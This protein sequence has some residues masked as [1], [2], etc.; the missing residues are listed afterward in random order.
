[1]Q[2]RSAFYS[3]GGM[4]APIVAG[5]GLSMPLIICGLFC[6]STALGG[7]YDTIY[8]AL[9]ITPCKIDEVVDNDTVTEITPLTR[10]GGR[11]RGRSLSHSTAGEIVAS[12][13]SYG[14]RGGLV[15]VTHAL[16]AR[17]GEAKLESS[18]L[19]MLDL[20]IESKHLDVEKGVG[21][22]PVVD[23]I[24][25]TVLD[26]TP[27]CNIT[28]VE[29]NDPLF[30]PNINKTLSYATKP[31]VRTLSRAEEYKHSSSG[32]T[33]GQINFVE[34]MVESI[35]LVPR[36]ARLMLACMALLFYS[37]MQSFVGWLPTYFKL[38]VFPGSDDWGL[39]G[40]HMVS[41]YFFF[42]F[43]GC[44]ASIPCSVYISISKMIKFHLGLLLLGGLAL[45]FAIFS[46]PAPVAS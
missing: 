5:G 13:L 22:A 25:T 35:D 36:K 12:P 30:E 21:H 14:V 20:I 10:S 28:L 3:I 39:M 1:M 2:A 44:V 33:P 38:K 19:A 40:P 6:A 37:L 45:Q 46:Q 32:L 42:M 26:A 41:V 17:S 43:V 11:N 23:D 9:C 8:T 24:V 34:D 29:R 15:S 27:Y 7:S 31:I 4:V 16:S 18:E